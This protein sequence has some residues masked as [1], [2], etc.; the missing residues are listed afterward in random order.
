MIDFHTH[1]L[2]CVDDGSASGQESLAMLQM[3][4]EQGIRCVFAT[5]HFVASQEEP[6][7]FFAR[8]AQAKE[9]L[10]AKEPSLP[11]ELRLGA[12]VA[13]YPGVSRMSALLDL[14][15]ENTKLVLLEMPQEPWSEYVL[16]EILELSCS[17]QVVPMLAHVERC[18]DYQSKKNLRRL[19]ENGVVMQSNASY[20]ANLKTRRKACSLYRQGLI[21][22]LGSDCH[23]LSHRPPKMSEAFSA[24]E[25]RLGVQ[26]LDLLKQRSERLL[27]CSSKK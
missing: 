9:S 23:N 24:M 11:C 12:E 6:Q 8:R 16:R 7:R 5:P 2:P 20:F 4:A 15:L 25:S 22:V 13:Y 19:L 10:L 21:H 26:A 1:V 27:F 3:L 18:I 14:R 17:G